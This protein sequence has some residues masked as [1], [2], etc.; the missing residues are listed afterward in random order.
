VDDNN[1]LMF[2]FFVRVLGVKVM[3]VLGTRTAKEMWRAAS[4]YEL[5]TSNLDGMCLCISYC[6]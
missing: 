5:E 4:F 6:S 2:F 3:L 1:L